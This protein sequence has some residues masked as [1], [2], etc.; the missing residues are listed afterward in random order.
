MWVAFAVDDHTNRQDPCNT[1]GE[2]LGIASFS[3]RTVII[4]VAT[5]SN[6]AESVCDWCR[7]GQRG[8]SA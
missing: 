7:T 2:I 8:V 3:C 1:M 5:G 4:T 6:E